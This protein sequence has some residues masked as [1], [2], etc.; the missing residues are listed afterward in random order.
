MAVGRGTDGDLQNRRRIGQ[1]VA[2]DFELDGFDLRVFLY[3][4]AELDFV[5]C[6]L[7]KQ[8]ELSVT[9]GKRKEHVSRSMRKLATKG[10]I[11][12]GQQIGRSLQ[13]R[14]NPD[15]GL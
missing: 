13:W 4:C 12:P 9:L 7:V 15:Y 10:I 3:L 11:L 8:I 1:L 6:I 5:S 2:M 14:L